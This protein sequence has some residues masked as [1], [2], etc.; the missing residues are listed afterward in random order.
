MTLELTDEQWRQMR[1]AGGD[2]VQATDRETGQEFV[3]L[4]AK[5][6]ER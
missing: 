1:Q 6:Y 3:L 2:P 5:V 4:P